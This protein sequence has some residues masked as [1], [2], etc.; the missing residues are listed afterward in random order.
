MAERFQL[1]VPTCDCHR[2][3]TLPA[4]WHG[5]TSCESRI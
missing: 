2:G 3:G 4:T 1:A 5:G